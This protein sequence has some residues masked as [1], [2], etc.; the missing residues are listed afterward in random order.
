MNGRIVTIEALFCYETTR[1]S[2]SRPPRPFGCPGTP[3]RRHD[4]LYPAVSPILHG[5]PPCHFCFD[6]SRL[7]ASH[8]AD[9]RGLDRRL[10]HHR[11]LR[12]PPLEIQSGISP[13]FSSLR[14]GH[15][16]P[17]FLSLLFPIALRFALHRPSGLGACHSLCHRR[18]DRRAYPTPYPSRS[19]HRKSP[20]D[21]H[22]ERKDSRSSHRSVPPTT[23][24]GVPCRHLS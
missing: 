18:T 23:K 22:R 7:F 24:P 12:R 19:R 2:F 3:V 17:V 16:P 11:P 14:H 4:G 5:D 8:D 21:P 20:R 1:P 15:G 9:H 13:S 10:C 6:L